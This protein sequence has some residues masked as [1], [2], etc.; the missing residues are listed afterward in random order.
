MTKKAS[1]PCTVIDQMTEGEKE[2]GHKA[3]TSNIQQI[4]QA[5]PD[6]TTQRATLTDGWPTNIGHHI[7]FKGCKSNG[8]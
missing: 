2:M 5:W 3:K 1:L 7:M 8:T 4:F 6:E